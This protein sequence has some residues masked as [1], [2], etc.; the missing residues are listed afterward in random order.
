MPTE[1]WDNGGMPPGDFERNP[2]K[3]SMMGPVIGVIILLVVA[4]GGYLAWKALAG[5]TSEEA[6]APLPDEQVAQDTEYASTTMKFSL[7]YPQGFTLQEPY[8]YTRVS[9]IK[10]ISGVKFLV[11]AAL[12]QGTNLA[13]DSGVSVEVLPRAN[14]CTGDIFLKANVR[15]QSFAGRAISFSVA[16]SSETAGADTFE[17][18]VFAVSG[19]KPCIAMRYFMH[20]TAATGT[21]SSTPAFDRTS[22]IA[23]FDSIRN[24]LSVQ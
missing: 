23:A 21:A 9:P 24:S 1:E 10:P 2:R 4:G 17:E 20:T 5:G 18:M 6:S 22:V 19:S 8:A 15:A 11:P 7:R 14:L 12:S 16:T 13:A 3:R